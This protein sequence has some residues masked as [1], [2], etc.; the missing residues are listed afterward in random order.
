[1]GLQ[2]L[3]KVLETDGVCKSA[4]IGVLAIHLAQREH[5]LS[6]ILRAPSPNR[7]HALKSI[8]AG[9]EAEVGSPAACLSA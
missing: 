6:R 9:N 4:L 2:A 3:S 8:E 7:M 1:M 5:Q